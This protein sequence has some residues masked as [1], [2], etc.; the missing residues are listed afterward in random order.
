MTCPDERLDA[1]VRKVR[2]YQMNQ[3]VGNLTPSEAKA[4]LNAGATAAYGDIAWIEAGLQAGNEE[5]VRW[6]YFAANP[7]LRALLRARGPATRRVK[8][9]AET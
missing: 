5:G 2:P 4:L 3:W 7:P 1:A 9:P 8:S 6:I